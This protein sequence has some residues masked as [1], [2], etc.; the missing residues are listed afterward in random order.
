LLDIHHFSLPPSQFIHHLFLLFALNTFL[1]AFPPAFAKKL[2]AS[3][4]PPLFDAPDEPPL[5]EKPEPLPLLLLLL[6]LEEDMEPMEPI[7]LI[8]D[9]HPPFPLLSLLLFNPPFI[10][11][12]NENPPELPLLVPPPPPLLLP[13]PPNPEL[14]LLLPNPV[15]LL[16]LLLLLPNVLLLLLDPNRF[17]V[18]GLL[19][20]V[21]NWD[22]FILLLLFT[23]E[24]VLAHPP[25][26]PSDF[27]FHENPLEPISVFASVCES[28][29]DV[30]PHKPPL[31]PLMEEV[32]APLLDGHPFVEG[33]VFKGVSSGLAPKLNPFD[34]PLPLLF[35]SVEE[36]EGRLN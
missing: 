27:P 16:L 13:N 29:T 4:L 22:A 32:D 7:G 3:I 14:P 28:F 8:E 25:V 23:G 19:G 26:V 5:N 34:A 18:S 15:L 31:P 9:P 11:V 2:P 35:D 12:E 1:F 33:A 36:D 30:F 17:E 10:G 24:G 20:D 6:L 21:P